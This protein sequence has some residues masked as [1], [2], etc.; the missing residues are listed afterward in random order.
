MDAGAAAND[1]AGRWLV[2]W[3]QP[4]EARGGDRLWGRGVGPS[5]GFRGRVYVCG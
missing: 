2:P 4:M 1:G 5:L 3:Q